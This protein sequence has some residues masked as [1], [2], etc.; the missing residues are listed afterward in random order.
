[1]PLRGPTWIYRGL[2]EHVR[3]LDAV[4]DQAAVA[5]SGAL[6]VD[7]RQP[8]L[9]FVKLASIRIWLRVNEFNALDT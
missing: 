1:M 2:S 5:D 3:K 9:A 4:R 7:R 8:V 6:C